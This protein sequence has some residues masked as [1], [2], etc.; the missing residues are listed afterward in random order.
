M[1]FGGSARIGSRDA[2]PLAPPRGD[3]RGDDGRPPRGV[4]GGEGARP[5]RGVP[6][7]DGAAVDRGV[8]GI[9]AVIASTNLVPIISPSFAPGQWRFIAPPATEL[10]IAWLAKPTK[11]LW[12]VVSLRIR[13]FPA[14]SPPL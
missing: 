4:T 14:S 7:C 13:N 3:G 2:A 9:D 10:S 1:S 11:Y 5:P 8:P 12:Y 6:G